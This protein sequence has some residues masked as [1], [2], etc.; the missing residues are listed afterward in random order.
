M[1]TGHNTPKVK[2]IKG[3]HKALTS[4]KKKKGQ[5]KSLLSVMKNKGKWHF[6]PQKKS[7]DAYY[8]GNTKFS[9]NTINAVKDVLKET[10]FE[11]ATQIW[12][13]DL[14]DH[15]K[16]L[17]AWN[18]MDAIQYGYTKENTLIKQKMYKTYSE[19]P[20]WGKKLVKK[21][22]LKNTTLSLL[23]HP[24][25]SV[26]P[27]HFDAHTAF[28][29]SYG[30]T[31]NK[32]DQVYRFLFFLEDWDWGHFSQVGNNVIANWKSGDTYTWDFQM[33]HLACN[34]GIKDRYT[35]QITGMFDQKITSK[36]KKFIK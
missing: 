35:L 12:K 14:K 30:H 17:Q 13:Q 21:T 33:Y 9:K 19:M 5:Y 3:R 16:N 8:L 22:K 36:T 31:K 26:N 25:G 11:D 28:T 20:T 18:K 34:A 27:W 23:L 29:K 32:K 7:Q 24:V 15:T 4:V 1:N 2:K 6:D 10:S